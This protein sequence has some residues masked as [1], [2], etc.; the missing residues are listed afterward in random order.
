M[1]Q[2]FLTRK[3]LAENLKC[4]IQTIY[5]LERTG[6]IKSYKLTPESRPRYLLEEVLKTMGINLNDAPNALIMER[7]ENA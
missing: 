4:N 7:A 2:T 1:A 3:Q 6:K 5:R